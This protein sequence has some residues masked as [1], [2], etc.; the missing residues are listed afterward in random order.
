MTRRSLLGRI[1]DAAPV[2][3]I[4]VAEDELGDVIGARD[5]NLLIADYSGRYVVRFD[6]SSWARAGT[7]RRGEETAETIPLAGTVYEKVLRTQTTDVRAHHGGVV[8]TVPVT[9]RGDAI[10]VLELW[11]PAA[12]DEAAGVEVAEVAQAFGYVVVANR[13][14]TDLFE[15]GQRTV[16]F[17]LAAEIQRRL[18]PDAFSLDAAEFTLAAWLEPAATVGGDTFD[19]ALDRDTL[20]LS[21][22]D[23]VGNDVRAALLATVLVSSLRNG[24]RRGLDLPDQVETANDALAEHSP[25]GE[26]VTGQVARI[27]LAT[28]RAAV[29]NAGHPFPILLRDGRVAEVELAIDLP[30]GL[31]PGP[32]HGVQ[33]IALRPGDRLP[34]V[35]DGVLDRNSA[36]V[37]V[38][39]VLG[40]TADL[41]PREVVRAV[42]DSVIEAT[43]GALKDD[44]TVLCLDWRG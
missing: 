30:F 42:S 1:D 17:T 24:R 29:V 11:M 39:A 5:V 44:S 31:Y 35:T 33:E 41:H 14:Y 38:P 26:F 18:L 37:D 16:P 32:R 25:V 19:Y 34:F 28:G 2:D 21:V 13:R 43:G 15:W 12:P 20:H 4:E 22:T 8:M 3:A 27:D 23:A 40:A 6:R 7:R 9:V 36:H 10:G